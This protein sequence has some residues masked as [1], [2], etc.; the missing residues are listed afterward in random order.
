MGR[1]SRNPLYLQVL[2][3]SVACCLEIG[4]TIASAPRIL[5]IYRCC[6]PHATFYG[7]LIHRNTFSRS[8][9]YGYLPDRG[10]R[11]RI[12][13]WV[14]LEDFRIWGPEAETPSSDRE[15]KLEPKVRFENT[16]QSP[17]VAQFKFQETASGVCFVRACYVGTTRKTSGSSLDRSS[18]ATGFIHH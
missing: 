11:V 4:A 17:L 5:S 12:G 16:Y 10:A 6:K 2:V 1:F 8:L 9:T 13:A 15:P 3:P 7:T 18:M 14:L